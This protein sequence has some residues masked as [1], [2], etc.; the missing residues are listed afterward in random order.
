VG[1]LHDGLDLFHVV[2]I[3]SGHAVTVFSGMVKKYAEGN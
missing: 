2:D 3:K 1:S